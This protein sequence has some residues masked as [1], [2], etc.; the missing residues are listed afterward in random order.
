MLDERGNEIEQKDLSISEKKNIL[1]VTFKKTTNS[2]SHIG[3]MLSESFDKIDGFDYRWN[4]LIT[5][6][7]LLFE[8]ID[9]LRVKEFIN[10]KIKKEEL[11]AFKRGELRHIYATFENMLICNLQYYD[12]IMNFCT[13]VFLHYVRINDEIYTDHLDKIP[14]MFELTPTQILCCSLAGIDST[15]FELEYGWKAIET[16]LKLDASPVC[17]KSD[18]E[19]NFF[20]LN[21]IKTFERFIQYCAVRCNTDGFRETFL[22]DI[23]SN[24]KLSGVCSKF[25]K[26]SKNINEDQ[27]DSIYELIFN[28]ES[29]NSR[30]YTSLTLALNKKYDG[31]SS[32]YSVYVFNSEFYIHTHKFILRVRKSDDGKIS[33]DYI[34]NSYN[35]FHAEEIF[36]DTIKMQIEWAAYTLPAEFEHDKKIMTNLLSNMLHE[37]YRNITCIKR[38]NEYGVVAK[39]EFTG[40]FDRVYLKETFMTSGNSKLKTNTYCYGKDNAAKFVIDKGYFIFGLTNDVDL[41]YGVGISREMIRKH[42]TKYCIPVI[43]YM[44]D[45]IE[46]HQN[47]NKEII[48][49]MI[50]GIHPEK[51]NKNIG[52]TTVGTGVKPKRIMNDI[53]GKQIR[54]LE[55]KTYWGVVQD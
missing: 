45:V 34:A 2:I 29:V 18:F 47:S 51:I 33:K 39:I 27:I 1:N 17:D 6:N 36:T 52:Y 42:Y 4:S 15:L 50:N 13:L 40:I 54:S 25:G 46:T 31:D 24:A 8:D 55:K 43:Q 49:V 37:N 22:A 48:D 38:M 11:E 12:R 21:K 3:N 35:C 26:L 23:T 19:Y 53:L 30:L 41:L 7:P 16:G 14:Y 44:A 5:S 32:Q 9:Y 28:Q 10:S 20:K